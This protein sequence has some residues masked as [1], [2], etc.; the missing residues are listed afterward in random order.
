MQTS[1]THIVS[2]VDWEAAYGILMRIKMSFKIPIIFMTDFKIF[3]WI[4]WCDIG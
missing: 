4:Y 1:P 2:K 3:Y